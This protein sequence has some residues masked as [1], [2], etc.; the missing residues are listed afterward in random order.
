M[1]EVTNPQEQS[2]R[3]VSVP[4][5]LLPARNIPLAAAALIPPGCVAAGKLG[6][7][8][9]TK[10]TW[11]FHLGMLTPSR[12]A[13]SICVCVCVCVCWVCTE[14]GGHSLTPPSCVSTGEA[15]VA[16]VHCK[17]LPSHHPL[18]ELSRENSLAWAP[19]VFFFFFL[20]GQAYSFQSAM[21]GWLQK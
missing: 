9:A 11:D 18:Q 16:P 20:M 4:L 2:P 7:S 6:K 10:R 1:A 15:E 3:G 19:L 14:S 8:E 21:T 17:T 12:D 13:E 5:Q